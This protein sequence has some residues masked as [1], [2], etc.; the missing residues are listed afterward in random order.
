MKFRAEGMFGPHIGVAGHSD[1]PGYVVAGSASSVMID[2]GLSFLGPLYIEV[3]DSILG[4]ADRLDMLVLTH[5]HYDHLG[6]TP[7]LKTRLTRLKAGGHGYLKTLLSKS[8]VLERMNE[9]NEIQR[10]RYG[11]FSKGENIPLIPFDLDI[12][13]AGGM[14]FDL[15]GVTCRVLSTPG[16]TRDSLSFYFPEIGALFAGEAVGVPEGDNG[17]NVQVE[18]LSSYDDYLESLAMLTDIRPRLLGLGHAWVFT[19]DDATQYLDKSL[20]ATER[21]RDLILEYLDRH[22]GDEELTVAAMVTR[23]YDAK[24]TI[25]QERNAYITNLRAQVALVA[26]MGLGRGVNTIKK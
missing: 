25:F 7:Y 23:E 26:G 8:T 6:A 10:E 3:L 20:A 21:Y 16:H 18:F 17:E 1:Y 19:D 13:L 5:S 2:A 24:G 14:E 11:G 4:S 9:L 22:C 15:G 12:E